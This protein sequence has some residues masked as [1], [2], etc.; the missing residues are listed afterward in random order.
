MVN[1]NVIVT[2]FSAGVPCYIP[3]KMFRIVYIL[4]IVVNAAL[5]VEYF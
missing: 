2:K 1:G 5:W 4:K 3:Y